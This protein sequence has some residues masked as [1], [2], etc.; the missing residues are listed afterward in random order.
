[1]TEARTGKRARSPLRQRALGRAWPDLRLRAKGLVVV[2]VPVA[3]LVVAVVGLGLAE[4]QDEHAQR[5]VL[6][7]VQVERQIAQVRILSQNGVTTYLLTGQRSGLNRY[8]AATRDLPPALDRLGVLVGDN[9]AQLGR[10]RRTRTLLGQRQRVFEALLASGSAGHGPPRRLDLVRRS[11]RLGNALTQQLDAMQAEQ[12]RLL[13][14]RQDRARR[15]HRQTVDSIALSGLL[16]LGGGVG[17][18]LLFTSGVTRRVRQLQGIAGRL[19]EGLPLPAPPGGGD[20]LGQLGH[21]LGVAGRLLSE[22]AHALRE[23]RGLLEHVVTGSPMVMFRGLLGGTDSRYVSPNAGRLLGYP[24]ERITRNAGFWVDHLH[25]DDREGFV[26]EL[27]R[28]VLARAGEFELEYRFRHQDGGYRWL[29]GVTRL[30][31]DQHGELVDTLGYALDVT[32]RRQATDALREREA[33]LQAVISTS[34]DVIAILDGDGRVRYL[35]QAMQ[36]LTGHPPGDRLGR[37][38]F[39][40]DLVHPD[41]REG[42]AA[43][44]RRVLAGRDGG[45]K[46]RVRV[47]HADGHWVVLESHSRPLGDHDGLLLV[48]RDV[49]R[50]VALEEDLRHAKLA[51]EQANQAKSDYLSRM[52]HELRTPLNAILGSAQLLEMDQLSDK[53]RQSLGHILAGARHLLGLINE[54]LDIA[55]IEAGRLP[56]SLERVDAGAVVAET[57]SLIRPLADERGVLLEPPARPC[58]EQVRGDRQRLLQILLNLLSNAVKYNHQGGS[59]QVVCEPAPGGRLRITVTDTGPG[60]AAESWER[61][62]VP[63]ERLAADRTAVE[64][65]GLGLPLS[66]RLAEAMGGT[67]ELTSAP[68]QGSSFWVELPLADAH[69]GAPVAAT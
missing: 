16:G 45:A 57:V 37:N 44:Q 61:L 58:A 11:G 8:R 31:Y 25:P 30:G 4:R 12:Q 14:A 53:Q 55:A 3:A 48:S 24:P 50:Q 42:F 54:V 69:L 5:A 65:T 26:A 46:L 32:E 27:R 47:R 17:A 9:P 64:G 29:Y 33:T 19:A 56:L 66:R 13:A 1:M 18:M 59:V 49:T 38:A 52:S 10:L 23:A 28:A 15:T 22:R 41:D 21:D 63:F 34:P 68:G 20:E 7:A 40:S 51:A 35:S 60:I 6:R 39:T 2:A 62:F 36:R 43:A 67:L